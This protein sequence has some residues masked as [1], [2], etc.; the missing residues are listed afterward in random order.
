[1]CTKANKIKI[2]KHNYVKKLMLSQPEVYRG[3]E[4]NYHLCLFYILKVNIMT[5]IIN[6]KQ[7]N[8]RYCYPLPIIIRIAIGSRKYLNMCIM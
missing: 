1:M 6:E 5:V 4:G 2:D 8:E 7:K 3:P